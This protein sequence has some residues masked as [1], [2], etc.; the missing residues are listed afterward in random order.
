LRAPIFP[1]R[2]S[3]S[4]TGAA[5]LLAEMRLPPPIGASFP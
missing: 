5:A 4:S 1:H 3:S 2:I